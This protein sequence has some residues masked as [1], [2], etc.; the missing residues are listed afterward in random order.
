[1]GL[2]KTA[3]ANE[4]A[5]FLSVSDKTV[6]LW[7]REFLSNGREFSDFFVSGLTAIF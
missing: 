1:M 6:R 7:R 2:Q 3:A 5:L 4:V